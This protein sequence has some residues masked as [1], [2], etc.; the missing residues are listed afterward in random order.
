MWPVPA[1]ADQ[2]LVTFLTNVVRTEQG[3]A[4]SM[5]HDGP[6]QS[7]DGFQVL[8]STITYSENAWRGMSNGVRVLIPVVHAARRTATNTG[9]LLANVDPVRPQVS[10]SVALP[11]SIGGVATGAQSTNVYRNGVLTQT[12]PYNTLS[13]LTL[14]P[15][16]VVYLEY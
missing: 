9:L 5:L 2:D 10:H 3:P 12:A 6:M 8:T 1:N 14:A 15:G 7:T 11:T 4:R 13:P 16:E